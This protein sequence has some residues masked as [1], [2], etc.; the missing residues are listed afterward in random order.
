MFLFVISW[1]YNFFTT[2][3]LIGAIG[4]I[5]GVCGWRRSEGDRCGPRNLRPKTAKACVREIGIIVD[6]QVIEA[7]RGRV[8]RRVVN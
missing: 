5:G 6:L 4:L 1:F 2:L 7:H 8:D 3:H